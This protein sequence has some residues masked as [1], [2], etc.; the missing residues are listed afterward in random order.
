MPKRNKKSRAEPLPPPPPLAE[1]EDDLADMLAASLDAK[2][3][4]NSSEAVPSIGGIAV[5]TATAIGTA[6]ALGGPVADAAAPSTEPEKKM[7]RARARIARRD[8]EVAEKRAEAKREVLEDG[9]SAAADEEA[10]LKAQCDELHVTLVQI[11][12]DGHCLYNAVADQ[13]N[14]RYPGPEKYTY[15]ML[16]TAAANYMRQHSDDFMPFISDF[17][18]KNVGVSGNSDPKSNFLRYCEVME[19]TSAW[20][21][22]PELLALSNVFYTPIHVVQA[23]MPIVKVGDEFERAPLLIS[24][25]TNLYGLGEVRRHT[26]LLHS[27]TTL[28]GPRKLPHSKREA[29]ET[30]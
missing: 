10:A 9:T 21:G 19:S 15:Q 22:Q 26:V 14:V 1:D 23:R 30:I 25:H 6:P 20:G 27:I 18:E 17:D 16:R 4:L 11:N 24:Y 8:A 28:C 12:P 7:S 13:L 5:G 29:E 3:A 2:D